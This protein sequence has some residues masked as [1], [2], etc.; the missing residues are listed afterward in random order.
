L[1]SLGLRIS[2]QWAEN[3]KE[4][5]EVANNVAT[6]IS[7]MLARVSPETSDPFDDNFVNRAVTQILS[8]YDPEN[9][10]FGGAPKFPP[11]SAIEL[12]LAYAGLVDEKPPEEVA[13]IAGAAVEAAFYTLEAMVAGGIHD[14][15]AGGFH[16]YS[17]DEKW[18]LPHF[19]KM[20]YDNALMLGNL[21]Q[22]AGI[23]AELEPTLSQMFARSAQALIDWLMRDMTN[24]KG[25]FFSAQDADSEGEEGKFYIW[26]ADEVNDILRHH[27]P[28]FMQSYGIEPEGNFE[29]EATGHKTGANIPDAFD[30][31]P[32]PA[33]VPRE[34]LVLALEL[35]YRYGGDAALAEYTDRSRGL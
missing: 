19:E 23:A 6:R 21:A 14:H 26:T 9:G 4:F 17:T 16:R 5:D 35:L 29:D 3:R 25:L 32:R 24:E 8:D 15:L 30:G 28:V 12:L 1:K 10:G 27:A 7:A 20:L 11:H 22:A 18:L 2:E 13:K 34:Y 31:G 33:E